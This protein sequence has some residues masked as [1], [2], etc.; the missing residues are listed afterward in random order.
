MNEQEYRLLA[1]GVSNVEEE[2]CGEF[3]SARVGD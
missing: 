3:E 1:L 2:Y